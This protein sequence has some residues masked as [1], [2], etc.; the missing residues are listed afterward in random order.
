MNYHNNH[1]QKRTIQPS[2]DAWNTLEKR[3]S[4]FEKTKKQ[5]KWTF[6]RYAA[7]I[8]IFV[9]VGVYFFGNKEKQ[10]EIVEQ[11]VLKV[12]E[13]KIQPKIQENQNV[14][15]TLEEEIPNKSVQ[16]TKV[17]NAINIQQ[18]N[19]LAV[20]KI[21]NKSEMVVNTQT[22]GIDTLE[23]QKIKEFVALVENIKKEKGEVTDLEIDQL[24]VAAQ[25]SL[26]TARKAG[27][28]NK[29]NSADLL[30]DVEY[31]LDKDFKNRL[32]EAIVNTLK[33]P[34]NIFVIRDN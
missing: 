14:I 27:Q 18:S 3:L 8:I 7:A 28:N 26:I 6:L 32:F 34:K 1:L 16:K 13:H 25:K 11:P 31:D 12:K 20:S 30:A 17:K 21:S 4:D 9:A 19:Q 33:E 2:E 5:N 24:L 23:N 29:F 15:A 22:L 10:I